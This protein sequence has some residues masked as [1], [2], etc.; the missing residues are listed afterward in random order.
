MKKAHILLVLICLGITTF[1]ML[2]GSIF[3]AVLPS[4]AQDLNINWSL[5]GI[6][7]SAW[8]GIS[9]LS[10]IFL[11]KYIHSLKPLHSITVVIMVLSLSTILTY[12]VKDFISL[13]TV[14]IMASFMVPFSFPLAAKLVE[15]QI[16]SERRGIATAMYNTGS[17]IG[18]ALAYVIVAI[19]NGVWR[20]AM[21]VAGLIGMIYIPVVYFLWKFYVNSRADM[22]EENNQNSNVQEDTE[23]LT[24]NVYKTIIWLSLGHFAAVY[25]WNLMFSWLSTFL[26]RELQLNYKVIALS[27]GIMALFSSILEIFVGM[28]SDRMEGIKKRIVPL[29]AG[30][31]PST[32]LLMTSVFSSSSLL[33]TISMS[34]SIFFWR[35]ST[36]SFWAILGDMVPP[37][38]FERA[39]GIYMRAVQFSGIVSSILNGYIVSLTGSMRYAILLASIILLFS[40]IFFTIGARLGYSAKKS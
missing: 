27:L 14:R 15:T 38:Y 28:W 18:L 9:I 5:I 13:N 32:V 4:I 3:G 1:S 10:T 21:I 37:K 31:M 20:N 16:S 26:I 36:P 2:Q 30:L 12:F 19:V 33:T 29:Y 39:S 24:K 6:M 22:N 40:P 25:T 23:D 7:M 34:L 8:T 35:L 17:M 11:G